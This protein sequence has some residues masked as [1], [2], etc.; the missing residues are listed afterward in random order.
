MNS[1]DQDHVGDGQP[2]PDASTFWGFCAVHDR[3]AWAFANRPDHT[4]AERH[5]ALMG[6]ALGRLEAVVN[7]LRIAD[8]GEEGLRRA[9]DI[10]MAGLKAM[11][12]HRSPHDFMV[13]LERHMKAL[14][15]E[16]APDGGPTDE[17]R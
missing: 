1:H 7:L 9:L 14:P 5:A 4:D 13:A 10:Y 15:R 12:R 8:R 6:A 2:E 16:D 17:Q 3:A 11:L